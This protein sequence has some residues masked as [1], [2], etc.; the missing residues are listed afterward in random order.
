MYSFALFTLTAIHTTCPSASILIQPINTI[1]T[2]Y[3]SLY[4]LHS[5]EHALLSTN[6]ASSYYYHYCYSYHSYSAI[7]SMQST[8]IY[9][10]STH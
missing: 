3:I 5:I 7:S 1:S 6:V 4:S 8:R 10:S 9:H 2:S